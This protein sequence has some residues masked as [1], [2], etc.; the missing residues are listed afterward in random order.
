MERNIFPILPND[1]FS[2]I[3]SNI[4]DIS[5]I[6]TILKCSKSFNFLGKKYIKQILS[7]PTP[8]P[9]S[10]LK[11]FSN[12]ISVTAPIFIR[13]KQDLYKLYCE[14]LREISLVAERDFA[15]SNN[16]NNMLVDFIRNFVISKCNFKIIIYGSIIIT[17]TTFQLHQSSK[18]ELGIYL[19]NNL[20]DNIST[21]NHLIID[22]KISERDIS[23]FKLISKIS[24]SLDIS[25]S[26][27]SKIIK[28]VLLN[29]YS[30]IE[31]IIPKYYTMLD[32]ACRILELIE[33]LHDNISSVLINDSISKFD[34]P[35]MSEMINKYS[36]IL[37]NVKEFTIYLYNKKDLDILVDSNLTFKILVP[38]DILIR[39]LP[40]R[41]NFNMIS[42]D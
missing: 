37:P 2:I 40:K 3:I 23:G 4:T 26:N 10:F 39:D 32:K 19:L 17:P 5:H 13:D 38:M 15:R 6:I 12:L 1:V 36:Q 20:S 8:I 31:V 14:N 29:K 24:L 21:I 41:P 16:F 42:L 30:A 28:I 27:I 22:T 34:V 7:T 18:W 35:L 33:S 25:I 9:I 11:L